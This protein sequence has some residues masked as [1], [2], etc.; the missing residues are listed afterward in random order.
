VTEC[1]MDREGSGGKKIAG[2]LFTET[3]C[4]FKII[5]LV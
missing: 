1:I 4:Y 5:E 3:R 2:M